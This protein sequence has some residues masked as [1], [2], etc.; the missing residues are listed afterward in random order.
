[1]DTGGSFPEGEAVE[2]ELDLYFHPVCQTVQVWH[3]ISLS[4]AYPVRDVQLRT[5]KFLSLDV[6]KED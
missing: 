6:N 2:R 1:M 3:Y 4:S 5:V